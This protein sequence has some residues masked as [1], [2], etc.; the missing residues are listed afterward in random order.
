M[1]LTRTNHAGILLSSQPLEPWTL[2]KLF[3]LW[4]FVL[5]AQEKVDIPLV[6]EFSLLWMYAKF[7]WMLFSTLIYK[8]KLMWFFIFLTYMVI[9]TKPTMQLR[10]TPLIHDVFLIYWWILLGSILWR[11]SIYVC[12]CLY[13]CVCVCVCVC[14]Y[15]HIDLFFLLSD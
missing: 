7:C 9:L 1:A 6:K 15:P 11:I 12:L 13:V 14:V 3:G 2:F 5:E 10:C 4:Y 8:T